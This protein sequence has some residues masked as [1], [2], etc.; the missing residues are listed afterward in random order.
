MA[1]SL[2]TLKLNELGADGWEPVQHL[3][4]F[5]RK[6]NSINRIGDCETGLVFDVQKRQTPDFVGDKQEK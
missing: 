4:G 3:D 6:G 1:L 5:F 2:R